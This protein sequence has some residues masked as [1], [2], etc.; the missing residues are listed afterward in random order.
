M[1]PYHKTEFTQT[2]SM[3][4]IYFPSLLAAADWLLDLPQI[5]TCFIYDAPPG[6]SFGLPLPAASSWMGLQGKQHL[7]GK[8]MSGI[9]SLCLRHSIK[10][11]CELTLAFGRALYRRG[12]WSAENF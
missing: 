4:I 8:R 11:C 1:R 6:P 5:D 12:P 10:P 2:S 7:S 9:D 3:L